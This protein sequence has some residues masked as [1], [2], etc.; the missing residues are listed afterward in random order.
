[1]KLQATGYGCGTWQA[2][3]VAIN[4]RGRP[5]R[6]GHGGLAVGSDTSTVDY[7]K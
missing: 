7:H 6:E 1:M 4:M 2:G 3:V 5:A